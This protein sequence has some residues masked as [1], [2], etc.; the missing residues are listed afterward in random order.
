M[1][2]GFKIEFYRIDEVTERQT[3]LFKITHQS[4]YLTLRECIANVSLKIL[5]FNIYLDKTH[6]LRNAK[7]ILGMG[8]NI[9][10]KF[11]IN[12]HNSKGLHDEALASGK[13]ADADRN[14]KL[15]ITKRSSEHYLDTGNGFVTVKLDNSEDN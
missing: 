11:G 3:L 6:P 13:L 8:K 4:P 9:P 10:D 1:K 5:K 2:F 14:E 15:G 12:V 7:I